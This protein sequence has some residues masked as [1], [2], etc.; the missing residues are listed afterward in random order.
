MSYGKHYSV[1]LPE[2]I[3]AIE[4]NLD[5]TTELYGIDGTFGGGG[6]TF[7]FLEKFPKLR[8]IC[9]DQD[10]QAIENGKK[11]ILLKGFQERVTLIH[12]NFENYSTYLGV[13]HLPE[14]I[15]F[16]IMDLGVSSHHFDQAEGG[17]SFR[18]DADLDMRMDRG[19]KFEM[20]AEDLVN[21]LDEVELA[22]LIYKY[23]EERF[24]RQI[25]RNIVEQ[26]GQKRITKTSELEEIIFHSYPKKLRFDRLHPAT[27]TFQ[28]LRIYV[29][30]E[31]EVLESALA[32]AQEKLNTPG[33]LLV[34]SFHSLE[35]RIVKHYMKNVSQDDATG[36]K[37]LTKKPIIASELELS[38]NSRS[39]SAKLRLLLKQLPHGGGNGRKKYYSKSSD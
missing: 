28:A 34:I 30:R 27:K 5:S 39:R 14:K 23:G 9:F 2:C 29:N 25:A 4:E 22:D 16:F 24:S 20:T 6:H 13:N 38:E 32:V 17:F 8:M 36:C 37:I 7:A 31:L 21:D 26:R 10:P 1:M 33:L 3:Q 18:K 19:S 11:N 12:D 35:D 15:D